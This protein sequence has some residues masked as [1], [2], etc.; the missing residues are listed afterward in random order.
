[1]ASPD[2]VGSTTGD[3]EVKST[4]SP[5]ERIE[6]MRVITVIMMMTF[7]IGIIVIKVLLRN[8]STVHF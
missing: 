5:V 1:M 4:K 7:R 2:T 8:Y 6:T 3:D